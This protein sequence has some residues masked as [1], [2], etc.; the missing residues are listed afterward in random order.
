MFL[1]EAALIGYV[2]FI[3]TQAH[4]RRFIELA[5]LST[6][7]CSTDSKRLVFMIPKLI[8]Q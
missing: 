8:I 6:V 7:R 1:E 3:T 4:A 2:I 5:G